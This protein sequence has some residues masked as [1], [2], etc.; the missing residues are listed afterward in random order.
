MRIR[1]PN[2]KRAHFKVKV[3][4]RMHALKTE[5]SLPFHNNVGKKY[6]RI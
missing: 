6:P 2:R 3:P 5:F 1:I 4:V